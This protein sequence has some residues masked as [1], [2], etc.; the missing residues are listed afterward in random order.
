MLGGATTS[1]VSAI[2]GLRAYFPAAVRAAMNPGT[3]R[4]ASYNGIRHAEQKIV[5][6]VADRG[7]H[8]ISIGAGKPMCDACVTAIRGQSARQPFPVHFVP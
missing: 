4:I 2:S 7:Y 1:E 8:L 3:V 5:R 6:W